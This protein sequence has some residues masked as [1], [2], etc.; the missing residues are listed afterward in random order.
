MALQYP[1]PEIAKY[2]RKYG[3]SHIQVDPNPF[4]TINEKGFPLKLGLGLAAA[5]AVAVIGL[6]FKRAGKHIEENRPAILKHALKIHKQAQRD[7]GTGADVFLC[8]YGQP[9]KF[10]LD[11]KK[12]KFEIIPITNQAYLMPLTLVWTGYSANSR[13]LLG[14]FEKWVA[15]NT[16]ETKRLLSNLI[17]ASNRVAN[18]WFVSSKSEVFAFLDDFNSA[19]N[20]C[21]RAAGLQYK[22]PI[23][24]ELE[25]WAKKNGGR[26]KPIGA[27]GGDMILLAGELP[28]HEL[29]YLNVP[30]DTKAFFNKTTAS[31]ESSL[32]AS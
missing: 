31:K 13:E 29:N 9:L 24:D 23:H 10:H 21:A 12:P 3:R 4:L 27:G 6:R 32:V 11:K 1:I 2:E 17:T 28:I 22:L 7:L 8:A 20:E 25:K 30:I 19:L 18:A 15:Q 5:E 26:A 16:S 14:Q